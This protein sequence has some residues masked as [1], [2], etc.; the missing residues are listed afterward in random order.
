MEASINQYTA[1]LAESDD[2]GDVVDQ[3]QEIKKLKIQNGCLL[4]NKALHTY[5]KTDKQKFF[6]RWKYRVHML[7][8]V[9]KALSSLQDRRT[10]VNTQI[11]KRYFGVWKAAGAMVITEMI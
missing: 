2:N 4:L 3:S 9:R 5:L 6:A 1:S 7:S 10:H 11:L 8:R